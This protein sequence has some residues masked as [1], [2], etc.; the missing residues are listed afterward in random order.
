MDQRK[1]EAVFSYIDQEK[2]KII[3][4]GDDFFHC[5]ELGFR[6]IKTQQMICQALEEMGIPYEK[7]A[8]TGVAASL[9]TGSSYHIGLTCDIDA[10]PDGKGGTIHSCG[11]S[12]QTA[13]GLT[14][15]E[16]LQKT[17][18]LAE[19]DGKVTVFFTPAEEFID[20]AYRDQL[21]AE[22]K[23]RS[24]SG[25][26]DMIL[27]GVFDGV[28]CILSCHANGEAEA[29]FDIGSTLAGF[30]AKKA[31][32]HGTA[33]HS[34]AAAHLGKNAL[35]GAVLCQNAIAFL[36]DQFPPEAGIRLHPVL[37]SCSGDVNT[38]P[39]QAVLEM[40]LRAN[41]QEILLDC[42]DRLNQCIYN[43]GKAL[44]LDVTVENTPGYL[45]LAQ[46][47]KINSVVEKNMRLFCRGEEDII[48]GPVSGASGDVGDLGYLIPTVQFGF[49]GIQGR[50]HS[51]QFAV[52]DPE[53][54]Y[55]RTAKILCGTILDLFAQK[56]LRDYPVSYEEKKAWYC[57]D[58]LKC[59]AKIS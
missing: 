56:E 11:H 43:C 41:T 39:D 15:L 25:K 6:E 32:F 21:I 34:G 44:G 7:T 58:W 35:H 49:S 24:R 23:I 1:K 18:V 48:H 13:A 47:K 4:R 36:K 29:R 14:V 19:T 50:F 22:G 52:I 51:D 17:N 54:C 8:Q 38:I 28:D 27:S 37:T 16:A 53:N 30:L 33:S 55:I 40:Y 46:S 10:L 2:Q 26:Q 59:T 20:F 45:P 57:K 12:I 5:A 31:V 3:Q 42:D 9:G